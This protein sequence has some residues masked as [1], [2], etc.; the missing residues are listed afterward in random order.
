MNKKVKVV[1][2]VLLILA[3]TLILGSFF[4]SYCKEKEIKKRK[5]EDK[6]IVNEIKHHYNNYVKTTKD[7]YIY[8][9]EESKYKKIGSITKD[10]ELVLKNQK[11]PYYP[12][13]RHIG[14]SGCSIPTPS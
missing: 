1:I 11:I 2:V 14:R 8:I 10:E 6:K 7:T 4:F 12:P 3:V 13:M 5:E 9:K